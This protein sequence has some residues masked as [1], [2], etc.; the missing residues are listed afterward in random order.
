[1]NITLDPAQHANQA[2]ISL[3]QYLI[4]KI[5]KILTDSDTETKYKEATAVFATMFGWQDAFP[6]QCPRLGIEAFM[7]CGVHSSLFPLLVNYFQN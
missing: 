5:Y 1:M 6:G 3:Q 4:N 7:M 2:G